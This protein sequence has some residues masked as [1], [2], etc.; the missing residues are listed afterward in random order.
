MGGNFL[1]LVRVL[2][3][4]R[5]QERS[6]RWTRA[7][8]ESHQTHSVAALRNY[9]LAHSPFYRDFHRGFETRPLQE[10]PILTKGTLMEHFDDLV[11][12]RRI[13]LADLENFLRS[14]GSD[15]LYLK[16]Y[17]V[18]ATSGSTGRRGVFVFDDQEWIRAVAAI[19]RP[20]AWA[21]PPGASRKPPRAA[22]IASAARWHYS[23]RVGQALAN[24]IA[25][26]LRLDAATPVDEL[27]TRLNAWQPQALATYPSVLR[28]LAAE[29]AAG[30][31]Q[32]PLRNIATSAEVL[33]AD[34]RAAVRRAWSIA[35]Q[36]TYGATE[37]APIASECP[38]GS[39]HLFE[40]GA[41][42]EITDARGKPVPTGQ[43]GE[44]VLLTVFGRHIQP[45]IRYEISDLV[46]LSGE[47]CVCGRPY[48]VIES[49]DGREED[50]LH[51]EAA[52]ARM[53]V[54]A[55]HPNRFH[56]ALEGLGV[57]A[58]QV[59]QDESGLTIRLVGPRAGDLCAAAETAVRAAIAST[60]ARVPSITA[61]W[62][63]TLER[64]ATGKAP[65]IVSRKPQA[66]GASPDPRSSMP[67][68][69]D[70]PVNAGFG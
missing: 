62:E 36:D 58:W 41:V 3:E 57:E 69:F 43:V 1:T 11:T 42:I 53:P 2:L 40:N 46:R 21:Q 56:E 23:A 67:D 24:R 27:V 22:L 28:Q 33:T 61:C 18:L 65:L 68:Q 5:A 59:I 26:A 44:R 47:R 9:A 10:L 60:G 29:Q 49:V 30:R 12:D 7:Q 13:R 34:V 50:I 51:F 6:C 35:V 14:D 4:R 20:I 32:I 52:G 54:V 45:L 48:R 25:P 37:Y 8:L 16:R 15:G 19:T 63:S 17:V 64:G 55:V 70:A 38:E 39:K 31:L 66:R